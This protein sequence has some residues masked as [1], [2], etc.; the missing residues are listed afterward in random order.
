M[1]SMLTI[2][3]SCRSRHEQNTNLIG[4]NVFNFLHCWL[5]LLV[6]QVP[7][8]PLF[9]RLLSRK[10]EEVTIT[11]E[12]RGHAHTLAFQNW[13][14][15][16]WY[17]NSYRVKSP[18]S[19]LSVPIGASVGTRQHQRPAVKP[20]FAQRTSEFRMRRQMVT[21]FYKLLIYWDNQHMTT[22]SG[23]GRERCWKE[24]TSAAVWRKTLLL[25]LGGQR[26]NI[27]ESIKVQQ[28]LKISF[29]YN[30]GLPARWLN[31]MAGERIS[32][33]TTRDGRNMRAE[34]LPC[35]FSSP[36]HLNC[37]TMCRCLR[38]QMLQHITWGLSIRNI[39]VFSLGAR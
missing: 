32:K 18:V 12:T 5:L 8:P 3:S 26:S 13:P 29:S 38:G 23:V 19:P 31:K 14:K 4:I 27:L 7:R 11:A 2:C 25:M 17:I 39:H 6:Q 22:I 24:K 28:E 15:W 21:D 9:Q 35:R 37:C 20:I 36:P 30:Q 1:L 33:I 10:E 16:M 34:L